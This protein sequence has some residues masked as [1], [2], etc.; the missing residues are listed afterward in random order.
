MQQQQGSPAARP[1]LDS[2]P[3]Q[4]V[5]PVP[6]VLQCVALCQVLVQLPAPSCCLV[7]RTS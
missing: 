4:R 1:I 7:W 5:P 6:R 2:A 3:L